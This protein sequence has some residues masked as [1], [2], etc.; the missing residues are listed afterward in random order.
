MFSHTNIVV[1]LA[2]DRKFILM[3]EL[4]YTTKAGK[5]IT[6]PA[7]FVTDFASV[8]QLFWNLIPPYGK[9]TC[10]AVVHDY[11]YVLGEGTK[12]AADQV[13]LE[14]MELLG[15]PWYKRRSMYRAVRL[16]GRG[17]YK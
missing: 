9:Y 14:A 6:V 10:A 17:N 1:Q 7:G 12:L 11:L 15:V 5:K 4:T 16:F 13:F 2:G 8:P 3:E